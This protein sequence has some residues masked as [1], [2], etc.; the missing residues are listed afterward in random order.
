[1][2][3]HIRKENLSSRA[4][5]INRGYTDEYKVSGMYSDNSMT[6]ALVRLEQ[7]KVMKERAENHLYKH[8]KKA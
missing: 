2:V 1:M 7:A 5:P 6:S 3:N 4:H 8:Q